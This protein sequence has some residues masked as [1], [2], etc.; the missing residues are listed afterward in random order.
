[1][2]FGEGLGKEEL[3]VGPV[4]AP[5]EVDV[6]LVP[7]LVVGEGFV[8]RNVH[9]AAGLTEW[10]RGTDED[11]PQ[12]ALGMLMDEG[13][14]RPGSR[15]QTDQHRALD[16]GGVQHGGEVRGPSERRV[17]HG[18]VRPVGSTIAAVVPRDHSVTSREIGDL[19]F[20]DARVDDLPGR[21]ED[22]RRVA[23][24]V[25]FPRDRAV[26]LGRSGHVRIPG[27]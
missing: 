1:V 13:G 16:L 27:A 15:G 3:E 18:I 24:A 8:E 5:P 25:R 22:D 10:R 11:Q 23:P 26:T 19:P 7:T 17:H 21:H 2:R 4:V 6:L 9:P 12:H 14:H 20:P